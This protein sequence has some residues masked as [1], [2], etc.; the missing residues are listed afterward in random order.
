MNDDFDSK[1]SGIRRKLS[2][3]RSVYRSVL[4]KV[5]SGVNLPREK[6]D[7]FQNNIEKLKEIE[8][9]P[10]MIKYS[11]TSRGYKTSIEIHDLIEKYEKLNKDLTTT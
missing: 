1:V 5:E 8:K 9:D 10:F 7:S 3:A 6:I 4:L 11:K 2:N